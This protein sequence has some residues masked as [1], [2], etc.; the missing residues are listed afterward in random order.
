MQ[1]KKCG[2][3][4][5][6]ETDVVFASVLA[7]S[8]KCKCCGDLWVVV[9]SPSWKYF[10]TAWGII[11]GTL[12]PYAAIILWTWWPIIISSAIM[13]LLIYQT[14]TAGQLKKRFNIS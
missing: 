3:N 13:A 9:P 4:P 7:N 14:A 8:L 11:S 2:R 12:S 6:R 5:L 1:C 10:A